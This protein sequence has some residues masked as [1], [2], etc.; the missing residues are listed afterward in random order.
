MTTSKIWEMF[1][2]VARNDLYVLLR[3]STK[4][5]PIANPLPKNSV[6]IIQLHRVQIW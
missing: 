3:R 5:W 1:A 6:A 2:D 4:D